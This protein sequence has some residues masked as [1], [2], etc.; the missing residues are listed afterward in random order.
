[1]SKKPAAAAA[2]AAPTG[3]VET[4]EH[5]AERYTLAEELTKVLEPHVAALQAESAA[6]AAERDRLNV[7]WAGIKTAAEEKRA[8]VRQRDAAL[9]EQAAAHAVEIKLHKQRVRD[10]LTGSAAA[11]VDDRVAALRALK[12]AG[13][14]AAEAE[15]ELK[16]DRRD[17]AAALKEVETGHDELVRVLKLENDKAVTTL[18]YGFETQARELAALYEARMRTT[19]DEMNAAREASVAAVEARKVAHTSALLAAHERAFNDMKAYFNDITHSNL[20]LIKVR[21]VAAARRRAWRRLAPN[22]A[23]VASSPTPALA[24]LSRSRRS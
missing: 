17:I 21:R 20:D 1:M 22:S 3:P 8:E 6:L 13:D 12:L 10:L 15:R 19:R 16:A 9:A 11:V 23:P 5:F 24:P 2:A 18:R 7:A 4:P 14:G